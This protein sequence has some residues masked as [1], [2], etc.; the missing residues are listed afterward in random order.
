MPR[1]DAGAKSQDKSLS[2][3]IVKRALASHNTAKAAADS[4]NDECGGGRFR[5]NHQDKFDTSQERYVKSKDYA[6]K[7][8]DGRWVVL[9]DNADKK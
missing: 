9:I 3:K 7:A 1:E 2:E 6:E 8:K 5:A 4:I